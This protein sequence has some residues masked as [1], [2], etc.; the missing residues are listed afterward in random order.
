MVGLARGRLPDDKEK[1]LTTLDRIISEVSE[2]A[3][4]HYR[5]NLPHL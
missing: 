4:R 2:E 1:L 3:L 5:K